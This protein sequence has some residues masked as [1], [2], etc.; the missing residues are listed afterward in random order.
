MVAAPDRRQAGNRN[1][2]VR[3]RPQPL[4]TFGRPTYR[5]HRVT[6]KQDG[7]FTALLGSHAPTAL[8]SVRAF[9][10]LAMTITVKKTAHIARI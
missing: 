3:P 6:S 5:P 1:R 7:N 9:F 8:S 10:Q 2:C 4:L